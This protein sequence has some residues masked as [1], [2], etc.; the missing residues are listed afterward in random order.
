MDHRKISIIEK[1]IKAYYNT[2]HSGVTITP[3]RVFDQMRPGVTIT[4]LESSTKYKAGVTITPQLGFD[5]IQGRGNN[6]TTA[7]LRPGKAGVTITPWPGVTI[8]PLVFRRITHLI[9]Q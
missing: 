2:I 9:G 5:Q 4:P 6:Y 7:R 1:H 3:L 8:T